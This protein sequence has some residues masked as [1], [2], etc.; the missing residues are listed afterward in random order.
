MNDRYKCTDTKRETIYIK[1]NDKWEKDKDKSK[2]KKIINKTSSK[3][4]TALVNW[5]DANPDFMEHDDKQLY[6]AKAMSALGKPLNGIDDKIVK[7]ICN[8]TYIK[9]NLENE[10]E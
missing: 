1:D 3:N 8:N 9:D 10:N 4:Y 2:I 6:Y 5:Q 7:K